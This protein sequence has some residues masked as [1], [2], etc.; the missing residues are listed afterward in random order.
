[1]LAKR[2]MKFLALGAVLAEAVAIM[3]PYYVEPHFNMEVC[4]RPLGFGHKI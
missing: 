3:P 1:M 4:T 2:N